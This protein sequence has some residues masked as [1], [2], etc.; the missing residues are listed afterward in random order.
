MT[1]PPLPFAS[2]ST[3]RGGG[4]P[5][6]P[7]F[8]PIST[9]GGTPLPP[10]FASISTSRGGRTP[11][12]PLFS[13]ISTQ[14]GGEPLHH[15]RSPRSRCKEEGRLLRLHS[16]QFQHTTTLPPCSN[17]RQRGLPPLHLPHHHHPPSHAHITTKCSPPQSICDPH[18]YRRQHGQCQHQSNSQDEPSSTSASIRRE[19]STHIPCHVDK[20]F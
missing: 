12:L 7:S 20:D 15:P 10:L 6:P 3:S 5:P 2:I 8:T 16:P 18:H 17:A 14:E 1:P 19:D 13:P 9:Q 11:P 4:T